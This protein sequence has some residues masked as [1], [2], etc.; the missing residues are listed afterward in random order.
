MRMLI[1]ATLILFGGLV[2][3][4]KST[5]QDSL[6]IECPRKTANES[7]W[8]VV[9]SSSLLSGGACMGSMDPGASSELVGQID[10]LPAHDYPDEYSREPIVVTFVGDG[11]PDAV[12]VGLRYGGTN[13]NYIP[14]TTCL[15][16]DV[17]RLDSRPKNDS[18]DVSITESGD[19]Q[20]EFQLPPRVDNLDQM[21]ITLLVHKVKDNREPG[22]MLA[23]VYVFV[24]VL[25]RTD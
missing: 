18:C 23:D 22:G 10:T 4:S 25:N 16:P 2:T 6:R 24:L 19:Y 5:T 1:L 8:D 21:T 12:E 11:V 14:V 20:L 3:V 17:T 7:P 15:A 13:A 9:L